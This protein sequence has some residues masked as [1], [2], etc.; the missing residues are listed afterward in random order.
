MCVRQWNLIP[1]LP[2]LIDHAV[3]MM[4]SSTTSSPSSRH[5]SHAGGATSSLLRVHTLFF[6]KTTNASLDIRDNDMAYCT[7]N[8][9]SYNY[10]IA[11]IRS[12]PASP[13]STGVLATLF[14]HHHDALHAAVCGPHSLGN[15]P[16]RWRLM[17]WSPTS[18]TMSADALVSYTSDELHR[19]DLRFDSIPICNHKY[20]LIC[21]GSELLLSYMNWYITPTSLFRCHALHT[22]CLATSSTTVGTA[23]RLWMCPPWLLGRGEVKDA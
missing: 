15:Q 9:D 16:R 22:L 13:F 18:S 17:P 4:A 11:V 7:C 6:D 2:P 21:H 1:S 10:P 5:Y 20:N 8:F 14:G 3:S 12:V 19:V 23:Q